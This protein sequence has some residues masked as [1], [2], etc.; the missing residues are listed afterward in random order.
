VKLSAVR[1]NKGRLFQPLG[2]SYISDVDPNYSWKKKK[3]YEIV[4]NLF[5]PVWEAVIL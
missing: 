4:K 5:L 1:T 3:G 2:R